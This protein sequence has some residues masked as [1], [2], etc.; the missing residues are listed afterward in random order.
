MHTASCQEHDVSSKCIL[1]RHKISI[2]VIGRSP[3][4]QALHR[5]FHPELVDKVHLQCIIKVL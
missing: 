3:L 2:L 1:L 5:Y 4:Q